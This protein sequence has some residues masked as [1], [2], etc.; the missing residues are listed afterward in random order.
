MTN[1][2]RSTSKLPMNTNQFMIIGM[3]AKHKQSKLAMRTPRPAQTEMKQNTLQT[4]N[5]NKMKSKTFCEIANEKITT[6][7][8]WPRKCIKK[9]T[10]IKM[11]LGP[12]KRDNRARTRR[13]IVWTWSDK[14][15]NCIRQHAILFCE[16]YPTDG[17]LAKY[18]NK[19]IKYINYQTNANGLMKI[20]QCHINWKTKKQHVIQCWRS[21]R[22]ALPL[23]V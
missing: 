17:I 1:K 10:M 23:Y 6:P 8:Q 20:L 13:P 12:T 16:W 5:N 19:Y 3:I 18:Y 9:L 21:V 7:Q 22:H 11:S 4:H 15:H 14:L 2:K